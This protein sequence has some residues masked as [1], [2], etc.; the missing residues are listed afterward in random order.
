MSTSERFDGLTELALDLRWSW[1]HAADKVRRRLDPE[2]WDLTHNPWVIL[3]TFSRERIEAM[4]DDPE[5]R[6][7]F[8]S[9]LQAKRQVLESPNTWTATRPGS[10]ASPSMICWPW[11]AAIR[12]TT[13]NASTWPIWP[14]G[15]ADR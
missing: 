11:V 6:K 15:E 12:K 9:Q 5:F 14:S 1:N 8:D 2:L 4:W 13:G 3:K 10:S 7:N